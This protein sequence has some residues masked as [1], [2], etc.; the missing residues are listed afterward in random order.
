[1]G[2]TSR[3]MNRTSGKWIV[4]QANGSYIMKMNRTSGK[5]IV[6]Q[7][8]KWIVHYGNE[9]YVREMDRT[10]REMDRTLWKWS[11]IRDRTSRELGPT[12][13]WVSS[14]L[15]FCHVCFFFSF[16]VVRVIFKSE[17]LAE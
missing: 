1:M 9:S 2:R 10:S 13:D 11:Y 5:W 7:S 8:S 17:V 14:S 12:V 3:E 15:T 6:H 4:H 16:R